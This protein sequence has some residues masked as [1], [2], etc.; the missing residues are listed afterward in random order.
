MTGSVT[1]IQAN[2]QPKG[3]YSLD[4]CLGRGGEGEVWTVTGMSLVVKLFSDPTPLR[5]LKVETMLALPIQDPLQKHHHVGI[6]WPHYLV[7]KNG[8]FAGYAMPLAPQAKTMPYVSS[9]RLRANHSPEFNWRYLHATAYNLAQLVEAIHQAGCVLGDMNPKNIL[10]NARALV[11]IIDTDSFQVKTA[12]GQILRC[13]VGQPEYTPPELADHDFASV[14]QAPVQDYF[15]LAVAIYALLAGEHPYTGKWTGS[16]DP[17][18]T[19][20]AI[21]SGAWPYR[22]GSLLKPNARTLTLSAYTPAVARLF[23]RAFDAG[24]DNPRARPTARDWMQALGAAQRVLKVCSVNRNHYWVGT[25]P[26]CTWCE[27]AEIL[28]LDVFRLPPSATVSSPDPFANSVSSPS[29]QVSQGS[30]PW[31]ASSLGAAVSQPP[32]VQ[33]NAPSPPPA[34]NGPTASQRI[35]SVLQ[36]VASVPLNH[37]SI[38]WIFGFIGTA[39]LVIIAFTSIIFSNS[40]STS[41]L[42]PSPTLNPTSLATSTSIR[43]P[44]SVSIPMVTLTPIP[45]S[46]SLLKPTTTPTPTSSRLAVST[47]MK[48]PIPTPVE[49]PYLVYNSQLQKAVN[50]QN[51]SEAIQ[52]INAM[53]KNFPERSLELEDYRKRLEEYIT[54]KTTPTPILEMPENP[55]TKPQVPSTSSPSH[56]VPIQDPCIKSLVDSGISFQKARQQCTDVKHTPKTFIS[57]DCVKS[58]TDLGITELR[59]QQ[60]CNQSSSCV[61]SLV[62]LGISEEKA[63]QQCG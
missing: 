22:A 25:I 41:S 12:K 23:E 40:E 24:H 2:G 28:K 56:T 10:V 5:R 9:P 1:F 30:Q 32:P 55:A 53:I 4:K 48:T 62:E 11:T 7:H 15:R 16:G 34:V 60:Q 39:I 14:D 37:L 43:S 27:R 61:T 59:A 8:Q 29:A 13:L 21:Q 58:L 47:P 44:A 38:N 51:W 26:K 33:L 6:T 36:A 52:I 57:N 35:S 63:R 49:T 50:N 19:L 17:P 31:G 18:S 3:T 46:T 45:S 54:P 20:E 42:T